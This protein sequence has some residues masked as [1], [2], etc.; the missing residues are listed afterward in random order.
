MAYCD[1]FLAANLIL[2]SKTKLFEIDLHFVRDYVT[3]RAIQ[4]SHVP[5]SIQMADRGNNEAEKLRAQNS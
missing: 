1:N 5:T 3:N 4:G 2:H